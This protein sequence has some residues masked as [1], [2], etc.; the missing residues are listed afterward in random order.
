VIVPSERVPSAELSPEDAIRTFEEPLLGYT[1]EEAALEARR[2]LSMD[3]TAAT[4]ACP[5]GI[6]IPG[7]LRRIAQ[8]DFDGAL[9]VILQAHPWPGIM[10]RHC[11]QLC[12][13]GRH[14]A[15]PAVPNIS[16]LERAAADHG[17]RRRF[18]FR[19]GRSTGKRVAIVGAGS[20]GSGA[21]YRL[22]Q[23]GHAVAMYD[24]LPVPGG[25]MFAGFPNFRLPLKV[26]NEENAL[27]EW[28]VEPHYGQRLGPELVRRLVGEYDAVLLSTGKFKEV[29]MNIP[30]EELDGVW[31]ALEFLTQFKLGNNPKVGKDVIVCGAGYTAQDA[32]RT[33]VRL[34]AK[35][36]VVYRRAQQ[37]MPVLPQVL[38][39]FVARQAAE[40][41]PYI[42][43]VQPVRVL[44][45]Q[46]KVVGI[47]CV[48]TRPGPP[49][50]SGRP[51]AVNV[52]GS[53]FTLECDTFIE[54]TGEEV[55]LSFLP[56]EVKVVGGHVWADPETCATSVPKLFAAGEMT[57]LRTTMWAFVSGFRAAETI[58][59][60]L[61]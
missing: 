6:D 5:F 51:D 46:G 56:P 19:P 22:R 60:F 58:D 33:C 35:A 59:R 21:A 42:F 37:D 13:G 49:D 55:D 47:E 18:P 61:K 8:G 44:G 40:G 36:R 27:H 25:M 28:G 43:Q 26:L 34:G 17:N 11:Q 39:K 53:N 45:K 29:R 7:F 31:D 4:Q 48:R 3:L 57:G 23:I 32:S 54:A 16:G 1:R 41:A 9:G 20:A 12:E 15:G 30:G 50:A 52:E 2:S 38:E 10:G 24:Q 14:V